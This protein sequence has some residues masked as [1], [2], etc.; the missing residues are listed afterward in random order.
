MAEYR[1]RKLLGQ[2]CLL[3]QNHSYHQQDLVIPEDADRQKNPESNALSPAHACKAITEKYD[4]GVNILANSR[5]LAI[6]D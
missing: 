4:L 1:R 3:P 5:S 2:D 6:R